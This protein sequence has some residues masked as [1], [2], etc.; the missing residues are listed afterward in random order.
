[1]RK[2]ANNSLHSLNRS[3]YFNENGFLMFH[4]ILSSRYILFIIHYILYALMCMLAAVIYNYTT[5]IINR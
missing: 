4:T 2:S 3:T 1:M 5:Y